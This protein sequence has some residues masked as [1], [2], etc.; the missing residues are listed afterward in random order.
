MISKRVFHRISAHSKTLLNAFFGQKT[1]KSTLSY[2]QRVLRANFIALNDYC[3]Q[4][5]LQTSSLSPHS[6]Q[7]TLDV[8]KCPLSC[9]TQLVLFLQLQQRRLVLSSNSISSL[10]SKHF[11]TCAICFTCRI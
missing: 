10:H 6:G 2:A 5:C 9:S 1:Q 7:I 3:I 8:N 4:T 11:S